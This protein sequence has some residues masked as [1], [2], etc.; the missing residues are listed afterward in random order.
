MAGTRPP[1]GAPCLV[2]VVAGVDVDAVRE[3]EWI[4]MEIG[5]VR[6]TQPGWI[7]SP[8]AMSHWSNRV[9]HTVHLPLE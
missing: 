2:T 6:S 7:V 1:A 4:G 9:S 3:L 8:C 5:H